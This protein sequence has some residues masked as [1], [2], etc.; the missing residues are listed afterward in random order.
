MIKSQAGRRIKP[1]LKLMTNSRNKALITEL[2]ILLD[3]DWKK[4]NKVIVFLISYYNNNTNSKIETK[5]DLC[6]ILAIA[7]QKANIEDVNEFT[8]LI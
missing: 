4:S 8:L 1:T 6:Y 3:N 2:V 7:I 5:T